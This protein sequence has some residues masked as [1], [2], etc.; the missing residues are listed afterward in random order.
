MLTQNK[1]RFRHIL[2]CLLGILAPAACADEGQDIL[3]DQATLNFFGNVKVAPCVI[4]GGP[5]LNVNL[6]KHLQQRFLSAPGSA[7]EW[8][9]FALNL[10]DCPN[11]TVEVV[12]TYSGI[13]SENGDMY[14]NTGTAQNVAIELQ[15]SDGQNLGNG[16]T[17][18]MTINAETAEAIF[19]MRAR[20]FS[21]KGNAS[22]GTITGTVSIAFT[23]K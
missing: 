22:A 19:S 8:V 11:S 16:K 17:Y 20:V 7:S 3:N 9:N 13:P 23:Y 15:R 10:R 14:A 1:T 4:A 21:A 6:G 12:A 18:P 2:L 5:T